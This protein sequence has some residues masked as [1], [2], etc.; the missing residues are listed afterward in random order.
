MLFNAFAF[1]P[2]PTSNSSRTSMLRHLTGLV[3]RSGVMISMACRYRRIQFHCTARKEAGIQPRGAAE[4]LKH[5]HA[6]YFPSY[7]LSY[8][9]SFPSPFC[10]FLPFALWLLR[11]LQTCC[12]STFFFKTCWV[13]VLPFFHTVTLPFKQ[14]VDFLALCIPP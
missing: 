14:R 5:R 8:R 12:F 2:T 3:F 13:T 7:H 1:T 9:A 11:S 4:W 10:L 6:S